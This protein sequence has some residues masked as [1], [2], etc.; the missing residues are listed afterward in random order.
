MERFLTILTHPIILVGLGGALGANLRYGLIELTR[1]FYPTAFPWGTL[2]V[3]VLGSF[4]LGL[5]AGWLLGPDSPTRQQWRL[6][7]GIGLCGG[8]TTFS[9]FSL[10]TLVLLRHGKP[11]LAFLYIMASVLAAFLAVW[12]GSRLG[13]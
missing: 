5:L 11:G 4:L 6:F 2:A 7:I 8:F 1:R 13:E 9:T 12:I 10:D 3:N